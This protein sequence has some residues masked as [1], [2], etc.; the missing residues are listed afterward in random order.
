M[1]AYNIGLMKHYR[2]GEEEHKSRIGVSTKLNLFTYPW[3]INKILTSSD[4]RHL[5]RLVSVWD[6]DT[7]SMHCLVFKKWATSKS[8]VL[9]NHW[10]KDFVRRR[11]LAAGDEIGM[12]WDSFYSRFNFSVLKRAPTIII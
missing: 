2:P 7:N 11:E 9:I 6:C 1:P 10:T 12:C 4:L 3:K 8:Y 5:T